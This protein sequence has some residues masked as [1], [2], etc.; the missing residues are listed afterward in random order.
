MRLWV[1]VVVLASIAV[2]VQA[3]PTQTDVLSLVEKNFNRI[4]DYKVDITV[5]VDSPQV[6]MPRST[7]TVYFKQPDKV[8]IVPKEGFV[9]LPQQVVPSNPV[10]GLRSNYKVTYTGN[11]K[12]NGADA[13]VVKMVPRLQ[14]SNGVMK[15]YVEKN[16]GIILATDSSSGAMSFKTI[17]TYVSVD[18][19]YWLPSEVRIDMKGIF[20]EKAFDPRE[21]RVRQPQSGTGKAVVKFA[22]YR[23]NRGIPDSVFSRGR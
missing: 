19:K 15:L 20:P 7:A 10:K 21:M 23:V 17:W 3:K 8:K 5:S 16:R 4:H 14:V 2:A 11:T 1:R 22:N 9:M 18:S 12:V 6:H 13:Y